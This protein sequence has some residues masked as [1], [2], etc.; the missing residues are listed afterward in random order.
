[1][2]PA[3]TANANRALARPPKV[4][5][6][7]GKAPDA[8]V[9]DESSDEDEDEQQQRQ[10]I[11]ANHRNVAP[12]QDD[13]LV[14]GGA[15]RIFRPAAPQEVKVELTG[16]KVGGTKPPVKRGELFQSKQDDTLMAYRS[17]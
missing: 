13:N 5:Y 17:G 4:R 7:K 3:P 8:A 6:F 1:M 9:S 11:K 2:A 15:G 12:V 16:V 10:S 14:A